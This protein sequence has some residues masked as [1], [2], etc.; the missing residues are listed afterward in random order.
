MSYE[1]DNISVEVSEGIAVLTVDRPKV[2]N[3]LDEATS[4]EIGEAAARLDDDSEVR[5]VIVT[6]AGD[7]AFV[8]GA[9]I[10][11]LVTYGPEQGRRGAELGQ[12][13]FD[14]IEAMGKPV[15][16]AVNGYALGGG[17]EL[18]LAC[19]MR[20]ASDRA[21]MG[22]PEINLSIIPGHG[23]T[24]RLPR[25]VG[26]GRALE[27]ICSGKPVKAEEAARIGLVNRVVPHDQLMSTAM[28][29]AR[30]FAS[31]PPIAMRYAIAA[32]NEGIDS[33][34][35][36]GQ[37]VEALY[38]GLCCATEDKFEGMT[39]FLEKRDAVWKGR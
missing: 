21:V 2:L 39:A 4:T 27:L 20:I 38:F 37:N 17:C 8:A 35:V 28:E 26:K 30:S 33:P 13:A 1:F 10:N 15:L 25:L 14:R 32:V 3:A 24:Q 11:V 12:R 16:A 18:A 29:M 34:L 36:E 6:G 23:G 9:D 22:L 19:H 31:K 5:A 7:K